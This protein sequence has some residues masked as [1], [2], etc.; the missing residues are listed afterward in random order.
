[1][2]RWL[3]FVSVG[4]PLLFAA[5]ARAD[6][7]ETN[8]DGVPGGGLDYLEYWV[9]AWN[10]P[11]AAP[12][13]TTWDTAG[14][15]GAAGFGYDVGWYDNVVNLADGDSTS[16][17]AQNKYESFGDV[18]V[19]V[20]VSTIDTDEEFG[21]I[22]RASEFQH[23]DDFTGVTAYAA[24]FNANDSPGIGSPMEFKLYK[25]VNGQIAH[26]STTYPLTPEFDDYITF[27][28]LSVV[29][30]HVAARLFEDADSTSPLSTIDWYDLYGDGDGDPLLTGYSGVVN[31]EGD[32]AD[33][34][35][36]YYDTLAS[37][38]IPEPVTLSLLLLGA[39]AALRARRS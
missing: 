27:I 23:G 18:K 15:L 11:D 10:G 34:L 21:V 8:K 39:L 24:T 7:V 5:T 9:A 20:A 3:V 38:V 16:Y 35:C 31:L 1:M 37:V 2:I 36:S 6:W 29:G 14:N 17:A 4:M 19:T 32:T 26:T 33:G 22:A 25:I 12:P 28:E 30:N 13:S